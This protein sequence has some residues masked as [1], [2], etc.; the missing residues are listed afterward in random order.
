[1]SE[2]SLL[3]PSLPQVN[4]P[5]DLEKI[6]AFLDTQKRNFIDIRPWPEFTDKPNVSFFIAHNRDSIFLKY[7]VEEKEVLARYRQIND[8]VY[9]DSCVE[10]FIAFDEDEAYYN[11]E[12]NRLGTCFGSF[13]T[14]RENRTLLPAKILEA[15]RNERTIMQKTDIAELAINWT[16]TLEIPIQIFCFH[17]FT[18]IRRKKCKVNFFKCGNDLTQPHYLVWNNIISEKPDFHLPEFFGG[19]EFI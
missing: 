16:L 2:K 10:F 12:F 13:G 1:M 17:D 5:A 11:L 9:K 18:S 7:D 4:K 19:A 6:S 15:I 8:P 14:Q 3:I